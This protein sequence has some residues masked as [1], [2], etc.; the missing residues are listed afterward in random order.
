MSKVYNIIVFLIIFSLS[1][2]EF[3]HEYFGRVLD[4]LSIVLIFLYFLLNKKHRTFYKSDFSL[5]LFFIPYIA[6]GFINGNILPSL[7]VLLGVSVVVLFTKSIFKNSQKLSFIFDIVI[8]LHLIAFFIQI[9]SFYIFDKPFS[10][11]DFFPFLQKSRVYNEDL[12]LLRPGGFMMEPNSYSANIFL[13][14]FISYKFNNKLTAISKIGLISVPFTTSLWGIVSIFMLV[15]LNLKLK[16]KVAILC[17]ILFLTPLIYNLLENSLAFERV[18][19]I[20]EDPTSDNSIVARLGLDNK[21]SINVFT[22]FLG[23]GINSTEFQGFLGGNGFSYLIFCLGIIGSMI[24]FFW[25]YISNNLTIS[26]LFLLFHFTFPYY[27]YLIFWVSMACIVKG[28]KKKE[29]IFLA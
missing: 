9:I 4:Y 22:L 15:F 10:Y 12:N 21:M 25:I 17:L 6:F 13:L 29:D 28:I 27:S 11:V 23:N 16:Y 7:A 14:T 26:I 24:L 8:G 3:Y 18:I 5:F 1:L 2:N 20:I 19:K